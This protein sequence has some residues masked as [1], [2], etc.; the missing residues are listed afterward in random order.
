MPKLDQPYDLNVLPAVHAKMLEDHFARIGEALL[1]GHDYPATREEWEARRGPRRERLIESLGGFPEQ[2]CDLTPLHTGTL[3]RDGFRIEKWRLQTRPGWYVAVNL[4]V[5]DDL[6]APLPAVICPHGH[7]HTGKRSVHVQQRCI[8][9]ARRGYVALSL[10][11]VGYDERQYQ[12]HRQ[13]FYLLTTGLCLAGL[14]IYDAIR[15]LDFLCA[16]EEVDADRIGCTGASGG[17]NQTTYISAI[18]ERVK[19]SAPVCS[20]E[21]YADYFHKAHCTCETIPGV[22]GY[23]DQPHILGLMAGRC[24]LL[25]VNAILDGGFPI[26]RARQALERAHRIFDLYNPDSLAIHEVYDGHAY[27]RKFREGVYRWFDRWLKGPVAGVVPGPDPGPVVEPHTWVE[28]VRSDALLVAGRVGLRDE[29]ALTCATLHG[30][31]AERV[32]ARSLAQQG[33]SAEQLRSAIVEQV[34]GGLPG[35]WHQTEGRSCLHAQTHDSFLAGD[36]LVEKVTFH[37]EPEII[38]PALVMHDPQFVGERTGVVTMLA[39]GKAAVAHRRDLRELCRG[40]AMLLALDFRG[41]G[42]TDGGGM[43]EFQAVERSINLGRPLLGWRVWDVLRAVDYLLARPD[44]ADTAAVWG[45]ADAALLALFAAALDER[46]RA[47][48]CV[49]MLSSYRGSAGFVQPDWVFPRNILRVCDLP[50]LARLIAP[51]TLIVMNPQDGAGQ[52]ADPAPLLRGEGSCIAQDFDEAVA[53][54]CAA[55]R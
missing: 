6:E 19:A 9:F 38:I 28:D 11:M 53:K 37:S 20:V 17:G 24:A 21:V 42:E 39:E 45:E 48:V 34:F 31:E 18:D 54:L 5:P 10:D 2:P 27:T 12:D 51:R 33:A 8:N 49:D 13:T 35:P 44:T 55:I 15:C 41:R 25:L 40:G 14:Q 32:Y 22:I 1:E 43:S 4:Y 23:A 52:D 16:R 47:A 46:I 3:Q 26:L 29:G 30:Q 50:D 7:W 36:M